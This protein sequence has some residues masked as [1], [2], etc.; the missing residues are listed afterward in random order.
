[1]LGGGTYQAQNKK[2][3]GAYINFVSKATGTT[4]FAER[5][6]VGYAHPFGWGEE[7]KI[8]EISADDFATKA[9]QY[10]GYEYTAPELRPIR[11]IFKT[12]TV[13]YTYKLRTGG[14]KAGTQLATAK[15][16]GT[17]GNKISVKV[18]NDIDETGK[19]VVDTFFDRIKVDTQKVSSAKDLVA[20]DYCS[21]AS[22]ATLSASTE[23]DASSD[24]GTNLRGGTD[25][26]INASAHAQF[27]SALES[28]PSVNVIAYDGEDALIT[29]QYAAWAVRMRNS[30]GL[31]VQA[32]LANCAY[33]SEGVVNV[34]NGT[35]L[36]PW[37]A[38]VEAGLGVNESATNLSYDGELTE[39]EIG[40]GARKQ[41]DLEK[42]IDKGQ[43]VIHL[44]D[45]E[46]RVLEDINSL[47]TL[48]DT[49]GAVFQDNKTIRV[50]DQIAR[51]I[52]GIFNN[53]Y[54]G[55]VPND[56]AGRLSFKSQIVSEH[57]TLVSLRALENFSEDDVS[58]VQAE[59]KRAVAVLDAVSITR[60]MEKLY[61][62]TVVG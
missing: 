43:F 60:T 17:A 30:V 46:P 33:D 45:G 52:A 62:K 55:E 53:T 28:Y 16:A 42:C 19:F 25:G 51:D 15:F 56:E 1:M 20:N 34:V 21:F 2:L 61:M 13:I 31:K 36:V 22:G 3:P 5:G 29:N 54:L 27:M 32:V 24:Y 50:I 41:N 38:G 48:S 9:M 59:D 44:V 35:K 49:K 40:A 10:F 6:Y 57:K 18:T 23:G 37:V 47:V 4:V 12:A 14:D 11:E 7:G 8:V 58:V 26:T 39:D